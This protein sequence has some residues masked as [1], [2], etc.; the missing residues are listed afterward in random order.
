ME[1]IKGRVKKPI[2]IVLY[3]VPGVGKTT[4]ASHAPHPL[5]VGAEENDE[6]EFTRLAKPKDWNDFMSQ[7]DWIVSNKPNYETLVIDTLDSIEKMLHR[8]IL[9]TDPKSKGSMAQAHGGFQKAYEIAESAFLKLR[10]LLQILRDDQKKGIILLAHSN[11]TL[12]IDTVLGMQYDCYELSIHK[13]AQGV[14]VDWV[15]AVLFAAYVNYKAEDENS[16]KIFAIGQGERVLYTEKR[17]GFL[18]KNRFNLPF[19]MPLDFAEFYNCYNAFYSNSESDYKQLYEQCVGMLLNL[20][21]ESL[22]LKVLESLDKAA[23]DKDLKRLS[24]IKKRIE[25]RIGA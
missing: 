24:E 15:S 10:S 23:Q 2:N 22:R 9:S 6:G 20:K 18:A 25:V 21:D 14:F 1:I 17:P 16:D 19:L 13:R 12:A 8:H 11:K 5:F 3:G 4:W 7:I